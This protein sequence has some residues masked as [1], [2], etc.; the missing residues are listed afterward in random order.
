VARP[1]NAL[2]AALVAYAAR[3]RF[4]VLA[5]ITAVLFLVDV[6]TPDPIPLVDELL[7]GLSAVLFSVW[8]KR[9]G[10]DS[11]SS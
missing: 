4:P 8:R 5:G 1:T 9:R 2:I 7:L 10:R 11:A 3:L 6:V